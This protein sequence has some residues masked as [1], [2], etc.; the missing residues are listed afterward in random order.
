MEVTKIK[1]KYVKTNDNWYVRYK[2]EDGDEMDF[3]EIKLHPNNTQF[4]R[5]G[6]ECWFVIADTPNLNNGGEREPMA[7]ITVSDK[8][9]EVGE[10]IKGETLFKGL[11]DHVMSVLNNLETIPNPDKNS[12]Q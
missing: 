7:I 11:N 8:V 1:G 3:S 6:K 10:K 12:N 9:I 4:A 5:D 2:T